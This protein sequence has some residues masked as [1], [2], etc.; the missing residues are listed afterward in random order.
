MASGLLLLAVLHPSFTR[1]EGRLA[2]LLL[3]VVVVGAAI[4][5]TQSYRSLRTAADEAFELYDH[6]ITHVADGRRREWTWQQIRAIRS[7]GLTATREDDHWSI[8]FADGATVSFDRYTANAPL[9]GA[10]L[11]DH[12]G[13]ARRR[14]VPGWPTLRWVMPFVLVALVLVC[15]IDV[16]MISGNEEIEIARSPGSFETVPRYS[17]SDIAVMGLVLFTSGIGA[18]LSL[19]YVVLGLVPYARAG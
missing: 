15:A 5:V 1:T 11:S 7:W 18:L 6:G 9:L 2:G 13:D 19:V 10:A 3:V 12:R 4:A 8:E 14:V 17:E 16:S